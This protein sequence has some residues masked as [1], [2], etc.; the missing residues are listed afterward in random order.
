MK[1][2]YQSDEIREPTQLVKAEYSEI[3]YLSQLHCSELGSNLQ[4]K[5]LEND[6]DEAMKRDTPVTYEDTNIIQ[7]RNYVYVYICTY[8]YNPTKNTLIDKLNFI[9]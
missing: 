1:T 5:H 3:Y 9:K 7:N 6:G 8:L 4:A 2:K